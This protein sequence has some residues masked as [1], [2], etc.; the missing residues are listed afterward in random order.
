MAYASKSIESPWFAEADA[1]LT[2]GR[3]RVPSFYHYV[4]ASMFCRDKKALE[5]HCR[6]GI[7][8]MILAKTAARCTGIDKSREAV[9]YALRNCFVEG[10]T[11]FELQ[12][13]S[14]PD[15]A[16]HDIIVSFND[17]L[18]QA[19]AV[20]RQLA[21]SIEANESLM[22]PP[23]VTL[24]LG[25]TTSYQ[26]PSSAHAA[27]MASIPTS[28]TRSFYYQSRTNP[29]SISE[30]QGG[31][32]S[33]TMRI[34]AVIGLPQIVNR[35]GSVA[36]QK[37]SSDLVSIIIPT[38][39][40]ES[41]VSESIDSALNQSWPNVEVI[42]I[43]DGSTDNTRKVVEKYG[44]KV[45]YYYKENGGIGSALNTGIKNMKGR[46]FKW[47]S[48]DDLLTIDAVESLVGFANRT[49]AMTTYSDYD[50][51][52]REGK[53]AGTFAEH[54]FS[55]YYEYA[56]ALW[57]RFIGN[58]SSVLID[59]YCFDEVGLFDESL[60]SAEDYDWWLRA[61]LLHGYRFFHLPKVTLKY[62]TH[63]AQLTSA[64]SHN[65]YLNAEKIRN[66]VRQ[67][68]ISVNPAWW[69]TLKSYQK[70]HEKQ[71]RKG[72]VARRLLRRSLLHMPEGMR[73]SALKTWH[74]SLRPKIDDEG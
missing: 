6:A 24:L 56:S 53:F 43:D 61:C 46:W 54:H 3:N 32:P 36:A 52:D 20:L 38:Y 69:E 1:V 4:W 8:T 33:D 64:V 27:L 41:L 12:D 31:P 51:V 48:S 63:G 10:K 13:H 74:E 40:R 68:I 25:I 62:R 35:G 42:V 71:N 29:E 21:S 50:I 18:D 22:T 23:K 65:A 70:L 67:D 34:I 15:Y 45:R 72:G 73:K 11:R 47:L 44:G 60:R 9:K 37:K 5:L 7:G 30:L 28:A 39:N 49:G 14:Q 57:S 58:G 2:S 17:D 16:D 55:S 66:R 59:R 19:I 26:D